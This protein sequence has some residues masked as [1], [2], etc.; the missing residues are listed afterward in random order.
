MYRFSPRPTPLRS[1]SS[2][3]HLFKQME[4]R[5]KK[6]QQKNLPGRMYGFSNVD[7]WYDCLAIVV[8]RLNGTFIF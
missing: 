5:Q 7:F 3:G 4:F 2:T 1:R 8:G 6:R